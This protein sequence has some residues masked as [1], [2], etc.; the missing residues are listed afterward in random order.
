MAFASALLFQTTRAFPRF[1]STSGLS[2][3]S[4]LFERGA[5]GANTTAF[6]IINIAAAGV[7]RMTSDSGTE[8]ATLAAGCFWGVEHLYR[9]VFGHGKGLLDA[10]VG[11][12]GGQ[13]DNPTYQ[14]VC[15]GATGRMYTYF[16]FHTRRALPHEMC[17][18]RLIL[19]VCT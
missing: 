9:K 6:S 3:S 19:V 10:K 7:R 17:E 14:A 13:T 12:A 1:C 15:S 11:Y 16:Q 5:G 4:S 18:A 2:V 8:K